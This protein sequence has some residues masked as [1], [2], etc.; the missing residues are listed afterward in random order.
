MPYRP[1]T[2]AQKYGRQ[3][4]LDG[5][6]RYN[7]QR[8]HSPHEKILHT[9]AWR[10]VR[11]MKLRQDPLCQECKAAGRSVIARHV[12]HIRSRATAP[13]LA[14]RMDNLKSVCIPCHARLDAEARR[15]TE[16]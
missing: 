15:M 11:A 10:N 5:H 9:T 13:E 16:R 7:E 1:P 12:H 2:Y 8:K 4:V 14:L 6:K 3:R